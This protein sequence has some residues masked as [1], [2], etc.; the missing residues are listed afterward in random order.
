MNDKYHIILTTYGDAP[1]FINH[2]AGYMIDK[3]CSIF[4]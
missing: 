2:V 1:T 3:P 4:C